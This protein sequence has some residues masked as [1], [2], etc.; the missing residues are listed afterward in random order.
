MES[1]YMDH[2]ATTPVD[3]RVLEAMLP[4]YREFFGNPS[5]STHEY[6]RLAGAAVV[7][8]RERVASLIGAKPIEV[9][10]TSGATEADNLAIKGAAWQNGEKGNHIITSNI[11]HKA[12][13]DACAW[14]EKEGFEVTYL[15]VDGYG[16]VDPEAVREAITDR[17]ILVSIMQVNSEVGT[18]NPIAGIGA[19]V[20]DRGILFHCDAVQ[21][22]GKI[23]AK[24]DELNVDLLSISAH[25]IYGPKGV[26]ALYVRRGVKL[27]PMMHGGGH[28]RKLR[29]GT[30]NAP[31]I[32]GL[33]ESCAIRE[34]EMD[35][36]AERLRNLRI[37]MMEAIESRIDH[38]YLNGHPEKR[39]PGNLNV[40]FAYVE[41]EALILSL[42]DVAVSSGSACTSESLE[43]SYV[44]RALGV[45]EALAHCSLRFGLGKDNTEEE[46]DRVVDLL[47]ENVVK[48]R[49]LSPLTGMDLDSLAGLGKRKP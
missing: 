32:V 7:E 12:V 47:E 4:Y 41:G 13:L 45:P 38:V 37:R 39:Q 25:K 20:K 49:E 22:V 1:I 27:V 40:S 2:N 5:S 29:S 34:R 44:L 48:L 30:L 35:E 9:I 42:R 23:P 46:V 11:E 28:E 10:F 18:I 33:G 26:G 16:M 14:L 19:V 8:A 36:E 21:G 15:P 31:G 43:S 24:V 17:T 3:P 6:G